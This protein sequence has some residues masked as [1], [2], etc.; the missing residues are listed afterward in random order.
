MGERELC[1]L[2]VVGS[3][4]IGS[5]SRTTNDRTGHRKADASNGGNNKLECGKLGSVVIPGFRILFSEI[6]NGGICRMHSRYNLQYDTQ[7]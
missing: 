5:T 4:P 3:I 2:E 6:V 7:D 1:K